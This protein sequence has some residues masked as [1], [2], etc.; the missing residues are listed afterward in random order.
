MEPMKAQPN[1]KSPK[2]LSDAE[3]EAALHGALRDEGYLFPRSAED[4]ASLE[5]SMDTTGVPTP[6]TQ[7]FRQ[8]LHQTEEKVVEL[9][10]SAKVSSREI[11]ENLAMAAR[12]GGEISE[13]IRKRMNTHRAEAKKQNRNKNDGAH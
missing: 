13:E 9:P 8:L 11:E 10:N 12:N 5:A 2:E 4:V 7:K 1:R 6:D 3:F